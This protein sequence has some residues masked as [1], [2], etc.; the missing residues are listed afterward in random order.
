MQ[1]VDLGHHRTR[2]QGHQRGPRP[3]PGRCG[4][5]WPYCP[6]PTPT[7]CSAPC[8]QRACRSSA[9]PITEPVRTN[10]AITESDGTTTKLNERGAVVD[11]ACAARRSPAPSWP[12]RP[13]R[14]LG[15]AV[16]SLPPGIPDRL[17]RPRGGA[18]GTARLPGGRRHL[19]AHRW[20]RWP[21]GSTRPR[22]TS[23]SPTPRSWP[24]LAGARA[25]DLEDA[26]AQ[27]DTVAGSR[28]RPPSSSTAAS[29][30]SWSPSAQREPCWSTAR[31]AW[32]AT[33]PPIV[34]RSTVGAG[35]ASLAGYVRAARRRCRSRRNGCRWPSPTAARA[36][37][38]AARIGALTRRSPKLDLD[39]VREPLHPMKV[40]LAHRSGQPII[41]TDLVLLDIDAGGD[42]ESVIAGRLPVRAGRRQ[43]APAIP[44][45]WSPPPWPARG[46]R[47]PDCPAGSRY[48]HCRSPYVDTPTIGFARLSRR[49]TSVPRRPPD[50]VFLIAAPE[51]GGA[52]HIEAAPPAWPGRWSARTSSRPCGRRRC[53]S[54]W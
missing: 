38:G 13:E 43:A 37:R 35:D 45:A 19:R 4:R 15:G 11:A 16:G 20:P 41:T 49:S 2:R 34:P 31:A 18:A 46:S 7:P 33:P 54:K 36:R 42:K 24:G 51:S 9:F 53:R 12:S 25:A 17:V 1:R 29:A 6:L 10:L 28:R 39:A 22:P 30:P 44:T 8:G 32:L 48:P 14:H 27:G 3:C 5:R 23:S 21:V 50:L 47:P 52:E 26:A 40:A